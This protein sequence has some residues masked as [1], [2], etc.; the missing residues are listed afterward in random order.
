M[1]TRF[2]VTHVIASGPTDAPVLVL[3]HAYFAT[4]MSWYR[5]VGPLS[6]AY[7]VMA[8]DVLGDANRSRPTRP[9]TSLDD[10]AAWFTDLLDGLGRSP[11][12]WSGTPSAASSPS[13]TPDAYQTGSSRW[14]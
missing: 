8:V 12:T 9:I 2:G 10:S 7:R 4:A 1:P 14:P 3:L 6:A 5:A 13:S 11:C